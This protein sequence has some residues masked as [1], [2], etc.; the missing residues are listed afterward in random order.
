MPGEGIADALVPRTAEIYFSLSVVAFIIV[1][2]FILHERLGTFRFS[3]NRI[4]KGKTR[5]SAADAK[6]V[7]RLKQYQ[8]SFLTGYGLIKARGGS[9][10]SHSSNNT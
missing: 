9:L 10:D 4:R 3:I 6:D 1:V 8:Q 5:N 2:E 7:S